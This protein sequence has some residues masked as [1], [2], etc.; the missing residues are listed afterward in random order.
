MRALGTLANLMILNM[1]TILCCIPI[2]T[3]G[4]SFTAM[5]YVVLNIIRGEETY[6][7]KQF[8]KSFKENFLQSTILWIFMVAVYVILFIDW[9]VLRMQGDQFPGFLIILLYAAALFIYLMSLYV[10]PVLSRYKNTIRGTIKTSY[11]MC[12]LGIITL[13]TI[14]SGLVIPIMLFLFY[15]GGNAI[16]PVII[17]FCFT[18][19]G[20]FRAKLYNGLFKKYEEKADIAP[21]EEALEE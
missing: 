8:F 12:V 18:G 16:V 7:A 20:Y 14:L 17:V 13:R 21:V 3:A 19:P 6:I 15:M 11:S 2:I 4:A 10:F 5:L 1:L 9:R